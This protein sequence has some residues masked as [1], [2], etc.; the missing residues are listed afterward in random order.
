MGAEDFEI[1]FNV[2]TDNHG[3]VTSDMKTRINGE[4]EWRVE[5]T[6]TFPTLADAYRNLQG[7]FEM[8]EQVETT[9]I[10]QFAKGKKPKSLKDMN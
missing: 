5:P 10:S 7:F 9:V 6:L 2:Y 1:T 8:M 3:K 4:T